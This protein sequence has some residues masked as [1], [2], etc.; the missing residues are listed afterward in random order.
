MRIYLQTMAA[1]DQPPRFVHLI[2]QR[3]LLGGWSVVRESGYQGRPG[4]VRRDHFEEREEAERALIVE[5][6]KQLGKGFRVVFAEGLERA[7]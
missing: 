3:D 2:L 5:R 7:N 4:R 6:D 1:P